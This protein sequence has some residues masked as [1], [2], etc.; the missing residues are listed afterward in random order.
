[1]E[2]EV[3]KCIAELPRQGEENEYNYLYGGRYQKSFL[4]AFSFLPGRITISRNRLPRP[5]S[6]PLNTE[7]NTLPLTMPHYDIATRAQAL[8]LKLILQLD[9]KQIEAITGLKPRTV[10]S[11]ADKALERGFDPTADP[12]VILDIHVCDAPRSGR[13]SKQGDYKDEVL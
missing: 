2:W 4:T 11:I 1:M 10:A 13:P 7:Q 6:F 8:T 5:P 3:T 12:P 9:N